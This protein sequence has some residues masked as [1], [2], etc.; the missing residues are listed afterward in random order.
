MFTKENFEVTK[1]DGV[2]TVQCTN[3]NAFYDGTDIPK[4]TIKDVYKYAGEYVS[5]ASDA[6]TEQIIDI[7][8]KDSKIESVVVNLPYGIS[9]RGNIC[10]QSKRSHTYPG[11]GDNPDVT[12][13]TY[14]VVVTDP[15]PTL[16]KGRIKA[17]S[18][19]ITEAVIK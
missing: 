18:N 6:A 14:K 12:K 19:L 10:I 4:E 3:E 11:I 5:K 7:M 13:S 1:S 15:L 17:A 9:K 8:Q 2:A 16:G